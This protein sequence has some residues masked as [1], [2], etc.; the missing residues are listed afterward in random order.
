MNVISLLE[1]AKLNSHFH[2]YAQSLSQQFI[3]GHNFSRA[4]HIGTTWSPDDIMSLTYEGRPIA[5]TIPTRQINSIVFCCESMII[6]PFVTCPL[7]TTQRPQH[8]PRSVSG[9]LQTDPPRLPCLP[10]H[11]IHWRLTGAHCSNN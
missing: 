6:P 9:H 4:F 11:A 5:Q 8:Y 10:V 7:T 2:F 3:L 1:L